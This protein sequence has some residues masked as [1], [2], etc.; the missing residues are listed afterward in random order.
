VRC[1]VDVASLR[2]E[3][4]DDAEQ[5]TQALLREPLTLEQPGEEWAYVRTAYDYGGWVR[6]WALEDGD[7]ELPVLLPGNP[8]AVARSFLGGP[9]E[10]GGMTR[11]GVDCSGLVH[12]A[13][14][15]AGRI[16]PRDSWQ[17]EA[18]ATPIDPA[19]AALGDL[20]TYGEGDRA[21]H[22]A[23]WLEDGRILH[24]TARDDLGVVAEPEPEVLLA[25]RR[26]V[27]RMT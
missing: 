4:A 16:V 6:A 24:A 18:A 19:E 2:A 15:L 9:Y 21:D 11:R 13:F 25:K 8:V 22:V 17:Q 27:C 14:R 1:R 10:W 20:V 12:M 23:F 7:G 26:V 5:V 3:P